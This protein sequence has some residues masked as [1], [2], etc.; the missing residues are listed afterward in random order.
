VQITK[1]QANRFVFIETLDGLIA[2]LARNATV[3]AAFKKLTELCGNQWLVVD[4]EDFYC[5]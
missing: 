4:H 3:T 2:S 1:H 5:R